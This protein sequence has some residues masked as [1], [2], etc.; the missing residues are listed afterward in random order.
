MFLKYK[1]ELNEFIRIDFV[2]VFIVFRK[3]GSV[4]T[5]AISKVPL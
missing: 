2:R 4:K 1:I 5:V 3:G